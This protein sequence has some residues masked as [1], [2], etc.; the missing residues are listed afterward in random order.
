VGVLA[1]A[2][3]AAPGDGIDSMGMTLCD[4]EWVCRRSR[5]RVSR[6]V[7]PGAAVVEGRTVVPGRE[8]LGLVVPGATGA[9]LSGAET[10]VGVLGV[11]PLSCC[12]SG[13]VTGLTAV[14]AGVGV[15]VAAGGVV[16]WSFGFAT[17]VVCTREAGPHGSGLPQDW[18]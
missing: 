4:T 6:E 9:S 17:V 12:Q 14:D 7:L 11:L 1:A 3:D 5:S 13:F 18:R 15:G 10:E 16:C 2:V 8:A